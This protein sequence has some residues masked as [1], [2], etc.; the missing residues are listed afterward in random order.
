MKMS[1]AILAIDIFILS[2]PKKVALYRN[3][4][5]RNGRYDTNKFIISAKNID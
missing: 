3:S 2:N 1:V 5:Y 4:H